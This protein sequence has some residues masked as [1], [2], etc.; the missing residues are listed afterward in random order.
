MLGAPL[1]VLALGI[2]WV[3]WRLQQHDREEER[4]RQ[5][6][7]DAVAGVRARGLGSCSPGCQETCP[8]WCPG[9]GVNRG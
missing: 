5:A 6:F 7:D 3:V 1:V 9:R 8:D 4:L 2:G